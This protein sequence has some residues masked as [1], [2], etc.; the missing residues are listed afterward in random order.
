[1]HILYRRCVSFHIRLDILLLMI[2]YRMR[3][4][5]YIY[6]YIICFFSFA[7]KN[8]SRLFE[9][10]IMRA[11]NCLLRTRERASGHGSII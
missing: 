10:N 6:I 2:V 7:R 4:I 8:E 3:I 9:G 5:I 11:N 1:M